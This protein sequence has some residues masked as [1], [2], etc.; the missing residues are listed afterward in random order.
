[1]VN[2]LFLLWISSSSLCSAEGFVCVP[3]S[4]T[5]VPLGCVGPRHHRWQAAVCDR[6]SHP[7]VII[8]LLSFS[9]FL[10][11]S[12]SVLWAFTTPLHPL[13]Q[14][15]L[16]YL[17]VSLLIQKTSKQMRSSP[18]RRCRPAARASC[19]GTPRTCWLCT[20]PA[21]ENQMLEEKKTKRWEL[22]PCVVFFH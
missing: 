20:F 13:Q 8:S 10:S 1:M 15:R 12:L 2:T 11:F 16:T 3:A 6:L 7:A 4:L 17:A 5:T 9:L 21:R 22:K 18:V 19:R 14:R